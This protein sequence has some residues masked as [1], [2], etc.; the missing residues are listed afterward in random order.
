MAFK[1]PA[2]RTVFFNPAA[3][4]TNLGMLREVLNQWH[5]RGLISFPPFLLEL[6]SLFLRCINTT[7]IR[8]QTTPLNLDC[9]RQ[10]FLSILACLGWLYAIGYD[11]PVVNRKCK[12]KSLVGLFHSDRKKFEVATELVQVLLVI[13]WNIFKL[14]PH[15][16]FMVPIGDWLDNMLQTA[17]ELGVHGTSVDG[18]LYLPFYIV[19]RAIHPD[20]PDINKVAVKDVSLAERKCIYYLEPRLYDGVCGEVNLFP[21]ALEDGK[22]YNLWYF[23]DSLQPQPF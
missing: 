12:T 9:T 22:N 4:Y 21:P 8:C 13:S 5:S 19:L 1:F 20:C 7:T 10:Y 23:Y 3:D 2:A 18:G 11:V 15:E 17:R 6:S 16:V 14:Y